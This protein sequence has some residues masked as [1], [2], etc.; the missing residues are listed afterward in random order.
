[1]IDAQP[2]CPAFV[3][4]FQLPMID[5]SAIAS[6]TTTT[7]AITAPD[8]SLAANIDMFPPP[9]VALRTTTERSGSA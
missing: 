8:P 1:M 9:V 5:T 4:T 6:V 7:A 3:N 2:G